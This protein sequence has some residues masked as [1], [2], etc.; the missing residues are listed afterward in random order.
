M[1]TTEWQVSSSSGC[2]CECVGIAPGKPLQ[3]G[4]AVYGSSQI[5]TLEIFCDKLGPKLGKLGPSKILLWQIG[6][7]QFATAPK[8][9]G[10]IAAKN[11]EGPNL[12]RAAVHISYL[13]I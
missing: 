11:G 13:S 5:E 6:P 3:E 2:V 7:Q 10:P 8:T 1:I 9:V 12:P 4:G